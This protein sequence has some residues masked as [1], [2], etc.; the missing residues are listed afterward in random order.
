MSEE[1]AKECASCDELIR[2]LEL[3][4]LELNEQT[5]IIDKLLEVLMGVEGLDFAQLGWLPTDLP[6]VVSGLLG[7]MKS[8]EQSAS[9]SATLDSR[10][11]AIEVCEAGEACELARVQLESV[12]EEVVG[13]RGACKTMKRERDAALLRSARD[14]EALA[15]FRAA[16]VQAHRLI[17]HLRYLLGVSKQATDETVLFE[18]I[19]LLS[20]LNLKDE[21]TA[22]EELAVFD[23]NAEA[24]EDDGAGST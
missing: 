9:A 5:D 24:E 8:L 15:D 12:K 7:Y 20:A 2:E 4:E 19:D 23:D 21:A 18:V 16:S 22:F 13:L 17:K 11:Y 1:S 10:L 6:R 14:L 3:V